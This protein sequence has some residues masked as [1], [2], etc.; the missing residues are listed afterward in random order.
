ME[1]KTFVIQW[2]FR[3]QIAITVYDS[4]TKLLSYTEPKGE[5]YF[6]GFHRQITDDVEYVVLARSA[7]QMSMK[8][9]TCTYECWFTN[10][11]RL[12]LTGALNWYASFV[13]DGYSLTTATQSKLS[14]PEIMTA[15]ADRNMCIEMSV[16]LCEKCTMTADFIDTTGRIKPA[17]VFR[18][19]VPKNPYDLPTWQSVKIDK[20]LSVEMQQPVILSFNTFWNNTNRNRPYW[21]VSNVRRCH[22]GQYSSTVR[23]NEKIIDTI[24]HSRFA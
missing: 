24:F 16:T 5:S 18:N 17:A 20:I 19:R 22:N 23:I 3:K 21:G 11:E 14:S 4:T 7:V 9:H 2:D 13:A 15:S 6:T 12:E 1:W 8:F 10:L